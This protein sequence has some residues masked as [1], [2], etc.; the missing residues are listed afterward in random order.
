MWVV[1]P[2]QLMVSISRTTE[3]GNLASINLTALIKCARVI[4]GLSPC[5]QHFRRYR[6]GGC[7]PGGGK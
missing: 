5:A 1:H 7:A 4:S 6:G 2:C 3:N